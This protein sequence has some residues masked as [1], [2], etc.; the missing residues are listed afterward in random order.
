MLP[1]L[2]LPPLYSFGKTLT[3]S[4]SPSA[5]TPLNTVGEKHKTMLT[6]FSYNSLAL[7]QVSCNTARKSLL[8]YS[9]AFFNNDFLSISLCPNFLLAFPTTLLG[10]KHS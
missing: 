8:F 10:D 7:T 1:P 6:Y 3:K 4:T 9:P 5:P 2:S